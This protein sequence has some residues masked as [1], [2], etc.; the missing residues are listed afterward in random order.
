M[1]ETVVSGIGLI[2]N[3]LGVVWLALSMRAHWIQARGPLP[4]TRK[5]AFGLRVIGGVALAGSL[6]CFMQASHPSM[7]SLVWIM[8]FAASALSVSM[9]LAWRPRLLAYWVACAPR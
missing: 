7:A 5:T 8:S 4:L 6:W 1:A 2:L 9:V 3:L